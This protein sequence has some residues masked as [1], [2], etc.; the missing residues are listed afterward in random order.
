MMKLRYVKWESDTVRCHGK[1]IRHVCHLAIDDLLDIQK[2]IRGR[3]CLLANKFNLNVDPKP[4]LYLSRLL[5][6]IFG[7]TLDI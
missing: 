6:P 2:N 7:T 4:V 5:S 1:F 3:N